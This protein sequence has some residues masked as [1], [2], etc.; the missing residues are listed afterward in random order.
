MKI[1]QQKVLKICNISTN[2]STFVHVIIEPF[3]KVKRF[4][5]SHKDNFYIKDNTPSRLTSVAHLGGLLFL[6]GNGL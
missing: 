6:I 1:L 4:N 5:F 2:V 3:F